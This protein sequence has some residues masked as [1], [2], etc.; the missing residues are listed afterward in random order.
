MKDSEKQKGQF[1]DLKEPIISFREKKYRHGKKEILIQ[2]LD[3]N[4]RQGYKWWH[5][6][7]PFTPAQ[8]HSQPRPQLFNTLRSSFVKG[9]HG[10]VT[11]LK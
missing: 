3:Q 5:R 9:I 10:E 8:A 7:Y 11:F 6:L 2:E 1:A 4:C